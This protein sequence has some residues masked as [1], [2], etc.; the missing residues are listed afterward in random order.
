MSGRTDR[1]VLFIC[2]EN[3]CRSLMAEAI[4]NVDPPTGWRAISAGTRPADRP[5]LRTGPMLEEIGVPLPA[6]L[7]VLLTREMMDTAGIRVNM[8]CVDDASCPVHLREVAL[9]D[10]NL[11]DPARLD[12]TGF[13]RLRDRLVDCVEDLRRELVLADRRARA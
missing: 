3:A 2:V 10:W 8:G 5:N 13:R 12:D 9:R 11:E 7:P 1:L 4:F 6:H